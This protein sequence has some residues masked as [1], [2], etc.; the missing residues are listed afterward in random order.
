MAAAHTIPLATGNW[1]QLATGADTLISRLEQAREAQSRREAALE[2]QEAE[3]RS[4]EDREQ[5]LMA[6][7]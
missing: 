1:G 7:Q 4:V 2:Q 3:R 6:A 5:R